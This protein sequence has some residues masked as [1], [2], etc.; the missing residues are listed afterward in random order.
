MSVIFLEEGN[1]VDLNALAGTAAAAAAA[2]R[3]SAG[4]RSIFSAAWE[5]IS[6]LSKRA[7]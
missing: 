5:S 7:R 2:R 1:T 4:G 6:Q 3:R